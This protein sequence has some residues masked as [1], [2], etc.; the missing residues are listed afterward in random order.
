MK[1]SGNTQLVETVWTSVGSRSDR[2]TFKSIFLCPVRNGALYVLKTASEQDTLMQLLRLF[3][4]FK[5]QKI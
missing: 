3:N 5:V 4:A 2:L 1:T